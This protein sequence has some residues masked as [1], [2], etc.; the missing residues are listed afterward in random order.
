MEVKTTQPAV[1]LNKPAKDKP[2]QKYTSDEMSEPW[3][4]SS[5]L[6]HEPIE[7]FRLRWCDKLQVTKKLSEGW[8]IVKEDGQ[9]KTKRVPATIEDSEQIDDTVQ[10]RELIL[11]KMPEYKAVSRNKYW[12]KMAGEQVEGVA[13]KFVNEVN[14]EGK[15]DR[16]PGGSAYG[17]VTVNSLEKE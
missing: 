17:N 13:N 14:A 4:P 8:I 12:Q 1:K 9:D 2:K 7:G 3:N 11:M 16:G 6:A 15:T 5:L 10:M